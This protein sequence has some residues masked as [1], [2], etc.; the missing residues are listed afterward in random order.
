MNLCVETALNVLTTLWEGGAAG[1]VGGGGLGLGTGA[2]GRSSPAGGGPGLITA[3]WPG[4]EWA[5][6]LLTSFQ[7][8]LFPR[9]PSSTFPVPVTGWHFLHGVWMSGFQ[10][11]SASEGPGKLVKTQVPAPHRQHL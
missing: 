6:T 5:V 3:E 10:L 2:A 1:G 8:P 4:N 9:E 11:E 7:T